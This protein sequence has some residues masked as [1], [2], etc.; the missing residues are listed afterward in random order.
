MIFHSLHCLYVDYIHLPHFLLWTVTCLSLMVLHT[1][2]LSVNFLIHC[3]RKQWTCI[4]VCA[5]FQYPIRCGHTVYVNRF[6]NWTHLVIN[7]HNPTGVSYMLV[8]WYDRS[9]N[10][11]L[12][13]IAKLIDKQAWRQSQTI[14]LYC[15]FG[16]QVWRIVADP[17]YD[18]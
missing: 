13:L 5:H 10:K 17:I 2:T 16:M 3:T 8:I 12:N 15:R 4:T 1:H 9:E 11:F 18:T 6:C 14:I 7:E